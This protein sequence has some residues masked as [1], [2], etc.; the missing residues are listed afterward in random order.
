MV[1]SEP[2]P[3][4]LAALQSEPY[5]DSDSIHVQQAHHVPVAPRTEPASDTAA[6]RTKDHYKLLSR[7][8]NDAQRQKK[9]HKANSS[10][11]EPDFIAAMQCSAATALQSELCDSDS[12]HVPAAP[13]NEPASDAAVPRRAAKFGTACGGGRKRADRTAEHYK[14]LSR[15]GNDAKRHKKEHKAKAEAVHAIKDYNNLEQTKFDS[16]RQSGIEIIERKGLSTVSIWTRAAKKGLSQAA[17]LDLA[18]NKSHRVAELARSY[19]VSQPYVR[20]CVKSVALAWLWLQSYLLHMLMAYYENPEHIVSWF[21]DDEKFD[22]TI[23]TL[24]LETHPDL[25]KEQQRAG[26]NVCVIRRKVVWR[27][28]KFPKPLFLCLIVLPVVIVGTASAGALHN[29]LHGMGS[30]RTVHEFLSFMRGKATVASSMIE[31]DAAGPNL[32][33]IAHCKMS[34]EDFIL[35]ASLLCCIHQNTLGTGNV[36][37]TIGTHLVSMLYSFSQLLSMGV[38]FL[39]LVLA[40]RR[41]VDARLVVLRTPPL[42]ENEGMIDALLDLLF[43]Q[44][45]DEA[46]K[47]QRLSP[48][49]YRFL[50]SIPMVVSIRLGPGGEP[51]PPSSWVL[52]RGDTQSS[53][54][55]PKRFSLGLPRETPLLGSF[56][57]SPSNPHPW[58]G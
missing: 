12:T 33:Y 40:V 52:P 15:F 3:D 17:R 9:E 25:L 42:A 16:R 45:N 14:L 4:F 20:I 13:R 55:S 43:P 51:H 8:G 36:I 38:Y 1:D 46:T 58:V 54:T 29:A 57:S 23:Q 6:G 30:S 35:V 28:P 26:W 41:V 27:D 7:L 50:G 44:P 18:C 22:E 24:N 10:E 53:T 48:L 21:I 56:S 32:S 49:S 34:Y 47:Q 37:G 39:R 31:S 19:R 11:S 2:E 5:Y